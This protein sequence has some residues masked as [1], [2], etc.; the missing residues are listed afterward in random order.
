[1]FVR[2]RKAPFVFTTE[3]KDHPMS[4]DLFSVS[5]F[6]VRELMSRGFLYSEWAKGQGPAF[7]Y[8]GN[9]RYITDDARREYREK[10]K[11]RTAEREVHAAA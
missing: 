7:F 5:Q 11:E 9:R 10:L 1:M 4:S 3:P 8:R 2:G 6:C